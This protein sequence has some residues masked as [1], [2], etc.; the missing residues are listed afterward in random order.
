ME[1][2]MNEPKKFKSIDLPKFILEV[3]KDGNCRF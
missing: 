3:K 1:K 2:E